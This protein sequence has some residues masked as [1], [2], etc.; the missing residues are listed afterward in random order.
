MT[1]KRLWQRPALAAVATWLF[2]VLCF[3][4]GESILRH[5]NFGMDPD[6]YMR[7]VQ[8]RDWVDGNHGWFQTEHDRLEVAPGSVI[9]SEGYSRLTDLPLAILTM[10]VKP[11][12]GTT[13][14]AIVI[15]GWIL[16]LLIQL[17]LLLFLLAWAYRPLLGRAA[18]ALAP[19]V[20]V[21]PFLL[22]EFIPGRIDHHGWQVLL[23]VLSVGAAIRLLLA[24]NDTDAKNIR[25]NGALCAIAVALSAAIGLEA[26][27]WHGVILTA[28]GLALI[29]RP[30]RLAPAARV[31]ALVLPGLTGLLLIL[32]RTPAQ[33]AE[34]RLDM[35]S[36]VT[37]KLMAVA[38]L[39]FALASWRRLADWRPLARAAIVA[40]AALVLGGVLLWN[41]PQLM[42]GAWMGFDPEIA[43]YIRTRSLE[44]RPL[45]SY[46]EFWPEAAFAGLVALT[47]LVAAWRRH[48]SFRVLLVLISLLFLMTGILTFCYATRIERFWWLFV[49]PGLVFAAQATLAWAGLQL[50]RGPRATLRLLVIIV[51][52][53]V[54][55]FGLQS[56]LDKA[57]APGGSL[58]KTQYPV[59]CDTPRL[60]AALNDLDPAPHR[61]LL[62]EGMGPQLAWQTPFI[63]LGGSMNNV[64]LGLRARRGFYLQSDVRMAAQTLRGQQIDLIAVCNLAAVATSLLDKPPEEFVSSV[65]SND[66]D[67][68]L[69]RLA[70]GETFEWLQPVTTVLA[71]PEARIYR[72]LPDKLLN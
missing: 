54:A 21:Q 3:L 30:V 23:L 9:G 22:A 32:L 6:N 62:M 13:T 39:L 55:L 66:P 35:L 44:L 10:T 25:R 26:M 68:M 71:P 11:F 4:Y 60:A 58:T 14:Q 7:A 61:I 63:Y 40:I 18:W 69:Q 48:K 43:A 19:L 16:P 12:G 57:R 41:V 27:L 70:R 64:A 65:R 28:V 37:V 33:M 45:L 8:V 24:T 49:M 20:L 15:A 51:L 31:I 36:L 2:V 50:Q 59:L 42:Q 53:I 17:P 1:N 46:T 5:E 52:A 72:V 34:L 29:Q 56:L 38:G 67:T 47:G